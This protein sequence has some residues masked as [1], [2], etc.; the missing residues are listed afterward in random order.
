MDNELESLDKELK[1]HPAGTSRRVPS[2]DIHAQLRDRICLL[3]YRPGSVLRENDL[4]AE[5]GVS[6]T[7]VREALQRLSAEGL[8][9]VRNGIGTIV[10]ALDFE[11]LQEIYK[12]RTEMAVLLGRMGTRPFTPGD[13]EELEVL[14]RRTR[15]LADTF[16]VHEYWDINHK[17]HFVVSD[18]ILNRTF[19]EI[20]DNLYF[21]AARAWYDV[22]KTMRSDA[23]SLLSMEITELLVAVRESDAEAVSYVKRNYISYSWQRVLHQ[24]LHAPATGP[25]LSAKQ[26]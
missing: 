5:F 17:L 1:R 26:G 2:H 9:E 23:I 3:E 15:S 22:A 10:T 8:V 4:A 12:V 13:T 18:F 11:E 6:R 20:W 19:R 24:A 14:L 7:P 25:R 16:D 21:K